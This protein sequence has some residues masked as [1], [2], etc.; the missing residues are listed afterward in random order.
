MNTLKFF[1]R[2][3][4]AGWLSACAIN[5]H[6]AQVEAAYMTATRY[7]LNGRVT[8]TIAPDPDGSGSLRLLATRNTYT[9]GVLAKVES[10]ELA[11]WQDETVL[12]G[13]WAGFTIFSTT[14]YVYDGYGRKA[15]ESLIGR[16]GTTVESL[17]Q[18]NY[19]LNNRVLCKAVRLSKTAS[20]NACAQGTLSTDGPDRVSS[21][22]YN[23]FG[24]VLVEQRGLGT[25]LQQI[26]VTNTYTGRRLTS[27]TDANGNRTELRYDENDYR[28][29][30][31][32]VY[33]SPTTPGTVN[34]NDYNQYTYYANG[35]VFT[36]RKRN[37]ATITNT[38]DANNRLIR[39]DLSDN[40]YSPD[41][42]YNYDLRG[43]KLAEHFGS[44]AGLG[45]DSSYDGFGHLRTN[46]V[47]LGGVS[48][49]LSYK[50]DNNGNRTRLTHPDG[51]FFE[52]GFDGLNRVNALT[53]A[54]APNPSS[55]TS[56]LLTVAYQPNGSL[57]NIARIGG[58]VT[59]VTLDN[60]NR[61]S[62][63]FQDFAG[64]ANDLTNTFT[65]NPA[66]QM[67]RL[68]QSN[69]LY[70]YVG[71]DTRTGNYIPNGLN[72]Y[73]NINGQTISYDANGNLT[74]DGSTTYTYDMENH[75][76]ATSGSATTSF[77]YDPR[78]RLFQTVI[79]GVTTQFLYD[80]DALIGEY[81]NGTLTRRY[82]HGD[83]VDQPLVQYNSANVG[84]S[85]RV[86]L[87]A[88]HQGSII[89]QSDANGS[90]TAR[91][92]YNEYGIPAA[93]NV[94][95]FAYTGQTWIKSSNKALNLYYYKARMYSPF[96]GRFLQT[97]PIGYK[98]DY[99]LYAYVGNDPLNSTDPS[100][101]AVAIEGETQVLIENILEEI[102]V[103]ATR[104]VR[105]NPWGFLVTQLF[106]G[107]NMADPSRDQIFNPQT[108]QVYLN[109][110]EIESNESTTD[111][112]PPVP[113]AAPGRETKGRT[114]QWEKDGGMG[115][116][117]KDFDAKNPKGVVPLPDG[118]RKGT[119]DDGRTI[120]VRPNSTEGRPTLEIQ[121]GKRRDKVR[122][123]P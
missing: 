15:Q 41:V 5:L 46:T 94:D 100:G 118:G 18:Y 34:E 31:K 120:V 27:Q 29:L 2:I 84:S 104:P 52:Y 72:E 53:E 51:Y 95:R 110:A 86:F 73:A 103:L 76:V 26:Y 57:N 37:G 64:T 42:Y 89:A 55:S 30:Q 101:N 115:Q 58:A 74:G 6:A 114:T 33:P 22:A 119:L 67:T 20:N 40:T 61:M 116:A 87:H 3:V 19:D 11:V 45:I 91:L 56:S 66:G 21:Y 65:Y 111:K 117:D 112:D 63:L 85:Y 81:V 16:D 122:Y 36:E 60:A 77:T 123:S 80:G 10:G 92:S 48:R 79:D 99:D 7:D 106:I 49:Q 121:D 69:N 107:G 102:E 98:D 71:A 9:N 88:D 105:L 59:S 54:T 12:P 14:A 109:E 83:Q 44:D 93:G 38:Y 24:Q 82:V 78:G 35:N 97:D 28:R 70:S 23:E 113:D 13:H 108:G 1:A 39:K 96:L 62:K 50:Y 25:A 4:V 8:G 75:L 90:V 32:R 68:V 43:L 17:V 47:T